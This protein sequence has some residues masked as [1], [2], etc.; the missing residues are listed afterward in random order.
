VN[1]VISITEGWLML[2]NHE[3][4]RGQIYEIISFMVIRLAESVL[5][6][7]H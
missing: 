5:T 3:F 2:G 6:V 1:E 4:S 7:I